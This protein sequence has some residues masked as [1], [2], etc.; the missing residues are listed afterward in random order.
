MVTVPT[1]QIQRVLDNNRIAAAKPKAA[2]RFLRRHQHPAAGCGD[3][4]D[5][6]GARRF[7]LYR[8]L[9]AFAEQDEFALEFVRAPGR[10]EMSTFE[11]T[12]AVARFV[13]SDR[14][15]EAFE[16]LPSESE[17]AA[18]VRE[19]LWDAARGRGGWDNPKLY[20]IVRRSPFA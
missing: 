17:F 4:M 16:R 7:D 18:Y 14:P 19:H 15:A 11:E 5:R 13:L 20:A 6:F 12:L 2:G 3:M 10:L 1:D 9:P 8:L